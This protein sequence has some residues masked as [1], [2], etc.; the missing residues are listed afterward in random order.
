M[1]NKIF[2]FGLRSRYEIVIVQLAYSA[3]GG[4]YAYYYHILMEESKVES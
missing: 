2:K 4:L 1:V 3:S